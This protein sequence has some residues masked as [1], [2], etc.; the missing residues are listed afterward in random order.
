MRKME[1]CP[2]VVGDEFYRHYRFGSTGCGGEPGQFDKVAGFEPEE[3]PIMGMSSSF[4]LGF[5]EEHRVDLALHQDRSRGREPAIELL[6]PGFEQ[7]AG[8]SHDHAV[9]GQPKRP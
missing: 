2:A 3:P 4:K 1:F 9:G 8:R 5:K 7:S 6:C